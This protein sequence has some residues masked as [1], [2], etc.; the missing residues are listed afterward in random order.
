MERFRYHLVHSYPYATK[1]RAL[2]C[3]HQ[4]EHIDSNTKTDVNRTSC[5][6]SNGRDK[7]SLRSIEHIDSLLVGSWQESWPPGPENKSF[8]SML[9]MFKRVFYLK[10]HRICETKL[11]CVCAGYIYSSTVTRPD[12]LYKYF[13]FYFYLNLNKCN[14]NQNMT[15]FSLRP[16]LSFHKSTF[17]LYV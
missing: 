1:I 11:L 15:Y 2:R 12:I 9:I 4:R 16:S 13:K 7:T 14:S 5:H 8:A 10:G 3:C 17:L 6:L